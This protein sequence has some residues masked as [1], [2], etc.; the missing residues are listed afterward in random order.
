MYIV[1]YQ[2]NYQFKNLKERVAE[3]VGECKNFQGLKVGH[4]PKPI[5]TYYSWSPPFHAGSAPELLT[6]PAP[7]K[8]NAQNN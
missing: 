7:S 3:K 4:G 5:S 2:H 8:F 1:M 6:Q